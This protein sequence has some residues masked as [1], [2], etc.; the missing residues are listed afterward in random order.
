MEQTKNNHGIYTAKVDS[1]YNYEIEFYEKQTNKN[2][3]LNKNERSIS[4][5][6]YRQKISYKIFL[7]KVQYTFLKLYIEDLNKSIKIDITKFLEKKYKGQKIN[8]KLLSVMRTKISKEILVNYV[9]GK[10]KV[11]D[12]DKLFVK[13]NN[14]S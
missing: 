7:K 3:K 12:Y 1:L 2:A 6:L 9:G 10:W 5:C 8:K 13:T 11:V 14:L 4:V